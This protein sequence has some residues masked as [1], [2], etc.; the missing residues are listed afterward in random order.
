MGEWVKT[1]LTGGPDSGTPPVAEIVS[2]G[3][4]AETSARPN[5]PE[6]GVGH[7]VE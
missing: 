5:H 1:P 7:F 3:H 2:R 6:I 4:E